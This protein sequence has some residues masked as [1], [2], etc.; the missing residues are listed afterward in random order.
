[1]ILRVILGIIILAHGLIHLIGV[2]A[3]WQL[4]EFD[5]ISASSEVIG[6]RLDV[7]NLGMQVL[8][9]LWLLATI[10]FAASAYGYVV[11]TD[12]WQPVLLSVTVVSLVVCI[13]GW[14]DTIFGTATNLIILG[15]LLLA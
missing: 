3:Y 2:A 7:G 1:M 15:G 6:G 12:W 5:D 10:G 9:I 4:V 11:K 8:G 13:L 14:K